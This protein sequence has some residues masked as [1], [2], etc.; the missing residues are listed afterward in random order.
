MSD[1]KPYIFIITFLNKTFLTSEPYYI[2]FRPSI[3]GEMLNGFFIQIKYYYR[4]NWHYT[5]IGTDVDLSILIRVRQHIELYYL[6]NLNNIVL[7][8]LDQ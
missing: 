7:K 1:M 4:Y 3:F 2:A 6:D 8:Y 5:R